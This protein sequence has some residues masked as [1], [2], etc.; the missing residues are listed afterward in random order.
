MVD[1]RMESRLL[2]RE[3]WAEEHH[4]AGERWARG[5][6]SDRLA[7][8]GSAPGVFDG[9]EILWVTLSTLKIPHT[10][11]VKCRALG[12]QAAWIQILALKCTHYVA[13]IRSSYGVDDRTHLQVV[14][15]LKSVALC[16]RHSRHYCVFEVNLIYVKSKYMYFIK[17]CA[18][19]W[20][21]VGRTMCLVPSDLWF[22]RQ[23]SK[24]ISSSQ[25]QPWQWK[26]HF[27]QTT[28]PLETG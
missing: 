7:A 2:T 19:E 28:Q 5:Q 25:A 16:L 8:G 17:L 20:R 15:W 11:A 3:G 9:L 22:C 26:L 23:G 1:A 27:P 18:T 21:R 6:G 4:W 12:S 13:S 24:W 10:A 14:M